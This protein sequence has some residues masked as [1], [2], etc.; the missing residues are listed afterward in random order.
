MDDLDKACENT[1]IY[2]DA[3]IKQFVSQ[4]TKEK[5]NHLKRCYDCDEMIDPRRL[6]IHPRALRCADCQEN[7]ETSHNRQKVLANTRGVI[8]NMS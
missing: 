5:I 7:H 2:L 3:T 1:Q 6:A 8:Q 4:N